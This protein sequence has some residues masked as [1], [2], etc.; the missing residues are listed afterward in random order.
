MGFADT[1]RP[2]ASLIV[3]G[4]STAGRTAENAFGKRGNRFANAVSW[5]GA[6][7]PAKHAARR[8]YGMAMVRP[9]IP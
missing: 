4:R 5:R 6:L 9:G 1:I 3:L 2:L 8:G 7:G